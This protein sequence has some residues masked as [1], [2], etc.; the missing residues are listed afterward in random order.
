ME[1]FPANPLKF[2]REVLEKLSS[3]SVE[4]S[5]RKRS[6]RKNPRRN[7]RKSRG[8]LWNKQLKDFE[9][10]FAGSFLRNSQKSYRRNSCINFW[11]REITQE[12]PG[13][14]QEQFLEELL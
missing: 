1:E 3:K 4:N 6:H 2:L 8:N 10:I 12:V 11:K 7:F 5:W 13:E 14:L 9:I